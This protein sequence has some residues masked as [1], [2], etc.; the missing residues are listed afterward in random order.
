[1]IIDRFSIWCHKKMHVIWLCFFFVLLAIQLSGEGEKYCAGCGTLWRKKN[2]G[3][4]IMWHMGEKR[5][6]GR[7][8]AR[9][10]YCLTHTSM[11]LLSCMCS[12][13]NT[14]PPPLAPFVGSFERDNKHQMGAK[15]TWWEYIKTWWPDSAGEG[16]AIV[17]DNKDN[18]NEISVL[19]S[20]DDLWVALYALT[21]VS[22]TNGPFLDRQQTTHALP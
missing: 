2:L 14:H 22:T 4:I 10:S 5:Q 12:V 17:Q 1:M 7:R 18:T 20:D 19:P 13:K 3:R 11:S 8:G 9:A 15:C 16:K 6:G 21:P